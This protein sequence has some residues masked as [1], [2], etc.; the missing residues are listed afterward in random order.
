MCHSFKYDMTL[1]TAACEPPVVSCLQTLVAIAKTDF[2]ILPYLFY[3][4]M[5]IQLR[6]IFQTLEIDFTVLWPCW[7]LTGDFGS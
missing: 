1:I 4:S 6:R 3:S 7:Y 5:V 2:P